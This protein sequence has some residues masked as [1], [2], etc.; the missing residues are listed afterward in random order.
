MAAAAKR[1]GN[2]GIFWKNFGVDG[3]LKNQTPAGLGPD[4][5]YSSRKKDTKIR[6][7]HA[8]TGKSQASLKAT[9]RKQSHYQSDYSESYTTEETSGDQR[10]SMP[11]MHT[12][13]QP[14]GTH[15]HLAQESSR[16]KGDIS[17]KDL[18]F[19][20][21]RRIANLIEELAR[22]S[23]EKEES[24][25]RL[26]NEQGNFERKIQDLEHQNLMIAKERESLQLQY[27]ECQELL[28][29]Y[30]QYLSEQ[31]AKLNQ[32][33]AHLTHPATLNKV[34]GAEE[35]PSRPSTSRANGSFSDGSYVG[36]AAAEEQQAS[37]YRSHNVRRGAAEMLRDPAS[38]SCDREF[39]PNDGATKRHTSQKRDC[40]QPRICYTCERCQGS[41]HDTGC[42]TRHRR[43]E[44]SCCL[45]NC[46]HDSFTAREHQRLP[47]RNIITAEAKEALT[48]PLLGHED[49]EEKRHQLLLQK[50]QLELEREKLQA[51]LAEQEERLSRQ[52]EQLRQSRL[53][54]SS[55]AQ[56]SS[57]KN[58][59]SES[60]VPSHRD[61]P[62]RS[63]GN[64]ETHSAEQNLHEKTSQVVPAPPASGKENPLQRS[65]RDV[66]TS[67]AKSP[68]TQSF[69]PSVSVI[70][71]IPENRL[72][73][74][75]SEILHVF[76]PVS[77]P[78]QYKPAAQRPKTAQR[79][80][81]LAGPK[82]GGRSLMTPGGNFSH[83]VQQDL[84]E[85]QILED[86][87]FIC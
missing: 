63:S 7:K 39:S 87:F 62:S 58:A 28:G 40:R 1:S 13:S 46:H 47:S 82:P 52:T 43:S 19:E 24:V 84:E 77:A 42:G 34:L 79:S 10:D 81:A 68:L 50:M 66:A 12:L 29:L 55:P 16:A 8:P 51:R 5:I 53:L 33:I 75:L 11:T 21:K 61:F 37:L 57:S 31:Q 67:P 54:H 48:R 60:E 36:L 83:G 69:P 65:R 22:V 17:L 35:T 9:G 20:D 15:L 26:K 44:S 2:S 72:D 41:C 25:Q 38:L 85:S 56:F 4:R 27:K 3:G 59:G 32:S 45:G 14:N 18:C 76:S 23:E 70:Q 30:Q 6:V 80:S 49:W 78:Q 64:V 73:H 86:I 74:S 71:T